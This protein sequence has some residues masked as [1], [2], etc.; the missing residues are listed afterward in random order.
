VNG[1]PA[2]SIEIVDWSPTG[3]RLLLNEGA[4]IWA[5]DAGG[6]TARI[7]DADSTEMFRSTS[8]I[9]S[10]VKVFGRYCVGNFDA[11]GFSRDGNLVVRWFPDNGEDGTFPQGS[12]VK[13]QE[14]WSLDLATFKVNRLPDGFKVL[15]YGKRLLG[16]ESDQN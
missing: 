3:H 9:D 4:W 7:Y 5:S 11:L 6:N 13:K 15:R 10:F 8:L 2:N 14:I 1:P 16:T 12:C